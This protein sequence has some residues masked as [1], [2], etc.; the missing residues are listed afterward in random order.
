[1]LIFRKDI[2]DLSGFNYILFLLKTRHLKGPPFNG[3]FRILVNRPVLRI[4]V[5]IVQ[6][7]VAFKTDIDKRGIQPRADLFDPAQIQIADIKPVALRVAMELYKFVIFKES[8]FST[9]RC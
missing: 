1:M 5:G 7:G 4:Q 6:E 8:N 3:S 9:R 2:V